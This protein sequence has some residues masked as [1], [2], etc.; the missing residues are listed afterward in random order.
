VRRIRNLVVVLGDQLDLKSS[1]F[2]GFDSRHDLVWMAEVEGESTQV[3]SHKVR[4]AFF[5]S[6]MRHFAAEVKAHG[7][8]LQYR[9]LDATDNRG[10][11]EAELEAAMHK[12][13]PEGIVVVEPGEWRIEQAIQTVCAETRIPLDIRPDRHFFCS[14]SEF[15]AWAEGHKQLRMEFFY[16]EM[17]KRTGILMNKGQPEGG[18]WNF[19]IENRSSFGDVGPALLGAE[20]RSF[21]PDRIT[22]QVIDLINARFPNHPG[23]LADFNF[24]VSAADAKTALQDFVR[25]RLSR[26]GTYQDAM[27]TDQPVLFHSQLSGAMNLKLIDPRT[28]LM[29]VQD[30]YHRG[31]V[32]LHSAEGYIRQ[33]L[34]WREYIR[35]VY[36]TFMPKY[37]DGNALDAREKL[38]DFYWTGDTEMNCLRQA[39]GQTL[40]YGYAHHIQ[41]LMVTGLYAL[42]FGVDPI[43]VHRWYLAIYWDAVEWVELPNTLGMS[44]FSDG[45]LM[46]S[47]PYIASGKYIQR[48]SNYCQG[49]R[50]NPSEALGEQ[51]CPFTTLYWDFLIRHETM[52]KRN[53]R[54]ALQAR[55]L[56]RLV[57]EKRRDIRK[58]AADI[59]NATAKGNY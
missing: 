28:V 5:L 59:R 23:S 4:I 19:D 8:S 54:T 49:C 30:A 18:R 37:V 14:R 11:I 36:W 26:F 42:L 17:R 25:H 16:R 41:R 20:A 35:G 45:G 44:Q 52:L 38:P 48:M 6:A 3:L 10:T 12:L 21:P 32:E 51:A 33:V 47:K 13:R 43:E 24:P 9:A 46:A 1:A 15:A 58:L 50:F 56:D 55:N 29:A 31:R 57:P 22:R 7:L 2:D 40:R 39:L 34:G 53:Q 27:W